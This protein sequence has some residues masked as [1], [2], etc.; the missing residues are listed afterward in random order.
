VNNTV[1][2]PKVVLQSV[3]SHLGCLRWFVF[4][5]MITFYSGTLSSQIISD[6]QA[7]SKPLRF[8]ITALVD[9][10]TMMLFPTGHPPSR[11]LVLGAKPS[12]GTAIGVRLDEENR[13]N[14]AEQDKTLTSILRFPMRRSC[15]INSMTISRTS[16][17][18]KRG[19]VGRDH[20]RWAE[21]ARQMSRA[22]R[23]TASLVFP[24]GWEVASKFISPGH[25]VLRMQGEMVT[26]RGR[27]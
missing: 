5:L 27:T 4:V 22:E 3:L 17:F 10:R 2:R 11:H 25:L 21:P 24:S 20:S 8:D 12:Y 13:S 6:E 19:F 26:T 1:H 9:Y 15:W 18:R 16:T 14:S 23:T 7:E